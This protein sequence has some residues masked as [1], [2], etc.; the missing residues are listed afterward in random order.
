MN[1]FGFVRNGV[2]WIKGVK[3]LW[4][5]A[6]RYVIPKPIPVAVRSKP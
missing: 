6:K 3:Q 4:H 5:I 1:I 2:P